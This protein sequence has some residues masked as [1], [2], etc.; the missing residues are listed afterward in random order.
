MGIDFRITD[1]VNENPFLSRANLQAKFS[2]KF[3]SLNY[4]NDCFTFSLT[5]FPFCL[6]PL[7]FFPLSL[8]LSYLFPAILGPIL[9]AKNAVLAFGN[10]LGEGKLIFHALAREN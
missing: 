10:K 2:P 4:R 7:L 8:L 1:G 3:R 5:V 9:S 6:R